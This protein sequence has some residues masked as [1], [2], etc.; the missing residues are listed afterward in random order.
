[1]TR[2]LP[3]TDVRLHT[4]AVTTFAILFGHSA[5]TNVAELASILSLSRAA[6]L[7]LPP[8]AVVSQYI[9]LLA[10]MHSNPLSGQQCLLF[11]ASVNVYLRGDV[12]WSVPHFVSVAA[13]AA[14]ALQTLITSGS[15]SPSWPQKRPP[16]PATA[17][18]VVAVQRSALVKSTFG[19][20]AL[21][22]VSWLFTFLKLAPVQ[23]S[24][25]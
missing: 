6:L 21:N 12:S 14:A 22:V 3:V 5:G 11:Y 2:S 9:S 17:P 18:N 13:G 10:P 20:Q 8:P 25:N 4:S 7:T 16:F 15:T 23:T 19:Q 24:S 1:M